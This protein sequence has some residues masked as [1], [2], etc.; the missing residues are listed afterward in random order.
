[1]QKEQIVFEEDYYHPYLI[2]DNFSSRYARA[3]FTS[4]QSVS[5]VVFIHGFKG[6]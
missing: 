4:P 3:E 5:L 6:N 2:F 1:V